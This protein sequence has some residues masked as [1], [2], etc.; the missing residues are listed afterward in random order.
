MVAF[1]EPNS[2]ELVNR[3]TMVR[4][5][6]DDCWD[7]FIGFW[8]EGC[9]VPVIAAFGIVGNVTCVFVFNHK[10]VDLKPSFSNI[11]KCLSIF[12]ILFLSGVICL[13]GLPN[14]S[15]FYVTHIEPHTTPTVLPL[16]QVAMTGSVYSVVAVALERYSNICQP[17]VNNWGGRCNGLGYILAII[18]FS[19]AYNTV[20]FFELEAVYPEVEAN[21]TR[22]GPPVVQFTEL[23]KNSVYATTYIACNTCFMGVIPIVVLAGLNYRIIAAMKEATK[24]HNNLSTMQR[25]YSSC[26]YWRKRRR[27][28]SAMTALLSGVVLVLVVCHTPKTFINL[29]ESYQ[30]VQF[31]ELQYEPLWGR[32]LIKCSHLLLTLSSAVNIVIYSFKDFKF[33]AVLR[34][35]C[36]TSIEEPSMTRA[37]PHSEVGLTTVGQTTSVFTTNCQVTVV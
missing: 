12:D 10:S 2:S 21:Q 9:L 5:C 7:E 15:N 29:Y 20:K 13:Y 27:R 23:R 28:D 19:F 22:V 35:F 1:V 4:S 3:S 16:T 24:R 33:R 26:A 32:I 30:M 6:S 31:G 34:L 37:V 11:L 14:M 25:R 17:F 18:L 8:I 36:T